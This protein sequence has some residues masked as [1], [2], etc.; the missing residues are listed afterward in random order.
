MNE[1]NKKFY[2]KGN[3]LK[4]SGP[5][6][7]S[8]D[9][10]NDSLLRSYPSQIPAPTYLSQPNGPAEVQCEFFGPISGLIFYFGR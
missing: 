8:P 5:F 7:E 3:S 9:F 10:K 1:G 4:R 2:R 6:N